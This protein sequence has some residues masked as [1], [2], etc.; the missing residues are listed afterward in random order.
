MPTAKPLNIDERIEELI[1]DAD[2]IT[3]LRSSLNRDGKAF[4]GM[5]K[6]LIRDVL[7][8]VVPERKRIKSDLTESPENVINYWHGQGW[9][10]A[11]DQFNDNIRNLGL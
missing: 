4:N 11:I 9:D 2:G 3:V 1:Q 8:E 10:S 7:V 5:V 6:Q